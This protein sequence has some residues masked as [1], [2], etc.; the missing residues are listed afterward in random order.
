[1]LV[2][3]VLGLISA[4]AGRYVK[5]NLP[6]ENWSVNHRQAVSVVWFIICVLIFLGLNWI[7]ISFQTQDIIPLNNPYDNFLVN[8]LFKSIGSG[9]L[10]AFIFNTCMVFKLNSSQ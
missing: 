6:V 8:Y 1:M 9:L 3:I 2:L 10:M 7:S 4:F 5:N